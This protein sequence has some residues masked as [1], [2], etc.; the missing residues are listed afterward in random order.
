[1]KHFRRLIAAAG[2][3]FLLAL[4]VAAS[5]QIIVNNTNSVTP[6]TTPQLLLPPRNGSN[7]Q[8]LEIQNQDAATSVYIGP[9]PGVN[10]LK[11]QPGQDYSPAINIPGNSIWIW[12]GSGTATAPT[13]G[14]EG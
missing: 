8:Y 6:T 1:M 2:C 9:T 11:L 7:R 4:P 14:W 3:L 10:G 12:L 5:Q 13:V